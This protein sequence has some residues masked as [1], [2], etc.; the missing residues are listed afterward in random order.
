MGPL[1]RLRLRPAGVWTTPWQADSLLGALACEWARSRG[2]EALKR[3]LLEPWLAGEPPFVVSDAFP[4]SS[5]PAPAVLPLWWG[6]PPEQRKGV[7]RTRWL[8]VDDFS[9]VQRGLMPRLETPRV[10]IEDHVRLRNSVSRA[11]NS[12][13]DH[14]ELFEIPFSD[15]SRSDD[16]EAHLTIFARTA[17]PEGEAMLLDA[18]KM[19][20]CTGYG[21]DASVGHGAFEIDPDLTPC[22]EFDDVPGAAGFIAFSTFQPTALDPGEG[23]WR[24]F[25]KY[26]KLAPE[27]HSAAV[28]KRPQVM[29]EPGACFR[30]YGA[31]KPFY[32]GPIGSD[33]LLSRP[34]RE[35]LAAVDVHPVQAAFALAVPMVWQQDDAISEDHGS[36]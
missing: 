17:D 13:G 24:S 29:L 12:A 5:L 16:T 34:A 10:I 18:L 3:D 27:L 1:V 20:G 15:F 30:T 23:F 8:G 4:G 6:W 11:T 7:K 32:G 21:A 36:D 31:P 26:G 28:H 19:L 33:R 2:A 14:G 35:S 22:P 9:R 25:V